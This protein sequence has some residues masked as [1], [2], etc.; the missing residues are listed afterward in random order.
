MNDMTIFENFNIPTIHDIIEEILEKIY[1]HWFDV[2]Y[3]N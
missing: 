2:Y 1:E 3:E